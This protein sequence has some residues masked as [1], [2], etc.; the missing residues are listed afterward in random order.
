MAAHKVVTLAL[1]AVESNRSYLITG[2]GNW[3]LGQLH[4]F[5]T[6]RRL[7]LI[8]EKILRPRSA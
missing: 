4:R 8:V 6:R 7:V 2:C 1:K 5:V 3:L